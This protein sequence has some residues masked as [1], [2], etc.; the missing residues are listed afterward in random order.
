MFDI[1]KKKAFV[2]DLDGTLFMGGQPIK[3]AVDFVIES[4]KSERFSF[5]YLTNNTSKTPEEYMTKISGAAIPVKPEQILTPL[6]TLEAYIREKDYKSVYLL[7]SEK[8]VSHMEKRL[9]DVGV[10]FEFDPEKNELIALAYDKE[11][12]YAK[13]ADATSLWNMR[14]VPPSPMCPVRTENKEPIDFV[15]T[16]PDNCCPS[17]RG[18]IPDVGGMLKFLEITNGMKPTHVFGKPSPSLLKTVLDRFA[19]EE[20]AVVGDRLYTDKAIADNA[21]VDFVCVLSGETTKEDLE[22]YTGTAPAI[23]VDTFDMVDAK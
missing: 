15:A 8:V 22:K 1:A 5:F 11:L 19:P 10:S 12:T 9:A 3:G 23:V 13:L 16:H 21:G 18:P 7:A 4:T 17:E 14:N 20:I 2:C 6:I